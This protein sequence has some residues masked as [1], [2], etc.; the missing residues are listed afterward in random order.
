M[1]HIAYSIR[2][3]WHCIKNSSIVHILLFFM[4]ILIFDGPPTLWSSELVRDIKKWSSTEKKICIPD[5]VNK[6]NLDQ[7]SV[8]SISKIIQNNILQLIH[9]IDDAEKKWF[10]LFLDWSPIT[11]LAY[12]RLRKINIIPST[13]DK[14]EL[15]C[16]LIHTRTQVSLRLPNTGYDYPKNIKTMSLEDIRIYG[17][18]LKEA[19]SKRFNTNIKYI[20]KLA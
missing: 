10:T 6:S 1:N 19:Y 4:Q 3:N 16:S 13:K 12:A 9:E 17:T 8:D 14:I 2:N 18:Y 5:F 20:W 15:I 7:L 11:Y